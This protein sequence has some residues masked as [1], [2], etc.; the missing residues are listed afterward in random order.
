[1][2]QMMKRLDAA[3]VSYRKCVE[4]TPLQSRDAAA[5]LEA[6]LAEVARDSG[7]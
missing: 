5:T 3:Y 6:E 1:M 7:E 4:S 2:T